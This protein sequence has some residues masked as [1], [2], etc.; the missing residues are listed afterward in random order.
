MSPITFTVSAS[1][2]SSTTSADPLLG[3]IIPPALIEEPS[4]NSSVSV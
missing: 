4:A 1:H 2:T 3:T